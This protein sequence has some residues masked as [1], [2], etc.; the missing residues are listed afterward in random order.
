M[1]QSI[2]AQAAT[3]YWEFLCRHRDLEDLRQQ[4]DATTA[5]AITDHYTE[6][7]YL[8]ATI[9]FARHALKTTH[10]GEPLIPQLLRD[11]TKV[12]NQ[13]CDGTLSQLITDDDITGYRH[14]ISR[15]G[16]KG[17]RSDG[18][19][20]RFTPFVEPEDSA[21][22]QSLDPANLKCWEA[23]PREDPSLT[24]A[25]QRSYLEN[26]MIA[27]LPAIL[28]ARIIRLTSGISVLPPDTAAAIKEMLT[29]LASHNLL[30]GMK[31]TIEK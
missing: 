27:D 12:I 9:D 1:H 24:L 23:I 26:R 31:L 3:Q 18:N 8:I 13:W 10:F 21:F 15:L 29:A 7:Q 22:W 6:G 4:F 19:A 28:C 14:P 20:A 2:K 30:D 16:L 5:A 11:W 25:D 17:Y